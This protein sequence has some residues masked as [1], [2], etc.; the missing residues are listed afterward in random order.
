[1]NI[2]HPLLHMSHKSFT[3]A[4]RTAA[5]FGT[6]SCNI[7]FSN[8]E[9]LSFRLHN[10]HILCIPLHNGMQVACLSLIHDRLRLREEKQPQNINQSQE[11]SITRAKWRKAPRSTTPPFFWDNSYKT[12]SAG[13]R[14]GWIST[15]SPTLLD[16]LQVCIIPL[17][18]TQRWLQRSLFSLNSVQSLIHYP[19]QKE[20]LF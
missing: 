12:I 14:R 19:T 11:H 20:W 3:S 18:N 7:Y 10:S 8:P 4:K 16:W 1:M 6:L 9:V 5:L 15:S 2:L 17:A 13:N